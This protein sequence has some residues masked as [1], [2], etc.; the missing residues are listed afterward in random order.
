MRT[1]FSSL[2]WLIFFL[3]IWLAATAPRWWGPMWAVV[4]PE[5]FVPAT[6]TVESVSWEGEEGNRS[7]CT[8]TG[9]VRAEGLDLA[10]TRE[11]EVDE[12][13][14]DA[15]RI[16]EVRPYAVATFPPPE[17]FEGAGAALVPGSP[18]DLPEASRGALVQGLRGP[19]LTVGLWLVVLVLGGIAMGIEKLARRGSAGDE[20]DLEVSPAGPQGCGTT[21]LPLGIGLLVA[22]FAGWGVMGWPG[23]VATGLALLLLHRGSWL[24]DRRA[25]TL[26]KVTRFGPLRHV[27]AVRSIGPSARVVLERIE[28]GQNSATA[29]QLSIA[30]DTETIVLGSTV[31]KDGLEKEARQLARFLGLPLLEGGKPKPVARTQ[32]VDDAPSTEGVFAGTPP[33]HLAHLAGP[34]AGPPSARSVLAAGLA[35]ARA[36]REA[37]RSRG[38]G[39][40]GGLR[41]GQREHRA[42]SPPHQ[43]VPM[44]VAPATDRP[45]PP[46]VPTVTVIGGEPAVPRS[47]LAGCLLLLV[48]I[49]AFFAFRASGGLAGVGHR[50]V[51]PAMATGPAGAELRGIGVSLLARGDDADSLLA[52]VR[53]AHTAESVDPAWAPAVEA[54]EQRLG[55]SRADSPL[56]SLALLPLDQA[57]APL[58]GQP[59]PESAAAVF[60]W[61]QVDERWRA[62]VD[63]LAGEPADAL[64][65]WLELQAVGPSG[66][67]A[68]LVELGPALGDTRPVGVALYR[69]AENDIAA[70]SDP[71]PNA[72]RLAGTVGE[73][74]ALRMMQLERF[75]PQTLPPDPFEW[76]R[77]AAVIRGYPVAEE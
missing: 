7:R 50:L 22:W 32:V 47:A 40:S 4:T 77:S 71:P 74:L 53:L 18:E 2:R 54:L 63:A 72:T 21:L 75:G 13:T 23:P 34:D 64:H 73:A 25:G 24:V 36:R 38:S 30:S 67:E 55:A 48:L 1:V 52:L 45:I 62:T 9:V 16:G 37:G 60:G 17:L 5:A 29:R 56:P 42:S 33:P 14:A 35:E 39:D 19:L 68:F 41:S 76:W 58:L 31:G 66:A 15:A 26:R 3:L 12:A 70:S 49:G 11:I 46:G 27:G 6:F 8:L 61:W 28:K 10:A 20:L 57:A 43:D 65:A 51:E 44:P 59:V 69:G